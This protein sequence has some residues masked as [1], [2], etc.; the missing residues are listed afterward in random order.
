MERLV[1]QQI[2]LLSNSY[3]WEG[4]YSG[5]LIWFKWN[6]CFL[7]KVFVRFQCASSKLEMGKQQW[8]GNCPSKSLIYWEQLNR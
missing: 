8:A 1:Y 6:F 4:K 7:Q 3:N 5:N 2:G